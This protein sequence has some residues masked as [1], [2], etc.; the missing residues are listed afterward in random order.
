MEDTLRWAAAI[1]CIIGAML[2]ASNLSAKISGIGFV[3]FTVSSLF[4]IVIGV[5][6]GE[7]ALTIQNIVLT[8]VNTF[9]I[10]RWLIRPAFTDKPAP[11]GN[12]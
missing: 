2:V 11:D 9:G 10:Y 1:F 6:S 4:W 12:D 8:A 3:V 7:A 5:I